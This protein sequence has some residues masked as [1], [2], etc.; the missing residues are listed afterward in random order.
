MA[1]LTGRHAAG[2]ALAL[3]VIGGFEGLSNYAYKDPVGIPTICFGETR[4]VRL[5]DYHSTAECRDML[6]GRVAEFARGIDAC[7]TAELPDPT[8]GAMVSLAYNI[9]VGAFCRS[10]LARKANAGDLRGACAEF[11][12]WSRAHGM[13]LPGL[14]KRRA[15][16]QALCLAGVAE[17]RSHG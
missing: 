2:L 6:A 13:T 7:L 4:N 9:G 1:K 5:G 11:P 12:R 17:G 15:E 16:E 10:T 3:T 8:Y 14:S